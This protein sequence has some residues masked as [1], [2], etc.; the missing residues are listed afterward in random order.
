MEP[1]IK[2]LQE[3]RDQRKEDAEL[4][5][6][7]VV[8]RFDDPKPGDAA[9][10][11]EVMEE[12]DIDLNEL[13]SDI[14]LIH[15]YRAYLGR[16]GEENPSARGGEEDAENIRK[17]HPRLF[18]AMEHKSDHESDHKSEHASGGA[19]HRESSRGGDDQEKDQSSKAT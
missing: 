1:I 9:T 15:Q 12:L 8:Q 17:M 19:H 10:L 13:E 7:Q 16:K 4:R 5:Y 14:L 6:S 18:L 3:Y 2:Q 11:D